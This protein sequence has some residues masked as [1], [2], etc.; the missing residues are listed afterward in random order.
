[1]SGSMDAIVARA[2]TRID[3][4]G[5]WT[6]VPPYSH[7]AGGFVCNVAISRYSVVRLERL[8]AN[9]DQERDDGEQALARAA[10][11]VSRVDGVR[12]TITNDFPLGAGLGGSSAAGVAMMG[13]IN[14]WCATASGAASPMAGLDRSAL[15]EASRRVE[16]DELGIAGGRQDHYAAAY[17]GALALTFGNETEIRH[18]ALDHA[19]I[20]ALEGRC[21]IAYTGQSRISGRTIRGV[22]D[23]YGARDPGVLAAL[24]AMKGLAMRMADALEDGDLDT[25]GL[26]VGEHWLHQRALHPAIT[27][28]LIDTLVARAMTAGA[29]GAKALGASGGGS[30]LLIAARGF[31]ERVRRAA[32]EMATLIPFTVDQHGFTLL[33]HS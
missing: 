26:L 5:G 10:L 8:A 4:G 25:L 13:A 6:D 23:A 28:P 12:A 18:V 11:R 7:E 9:G 21:I 19:M 17:G 15:A 14:A 30:V 32:E 3:F 24:A 16:V 2:P 27:T 22:L 20:R 1:M 31:E 33:H 29:I